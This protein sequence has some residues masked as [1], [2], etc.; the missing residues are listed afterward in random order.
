V[1]NSKKTILR[2]AI[3]LCVAGILL[4]ITFGA[5]FIVSNS[6]HVDVQYSVNLSHTVKDSVV[7]LNAAV[8]NN[9]NP[10]GNGYIVDFYYSVDG[11][12][13]WVHFDSRLTDVTGVV[14]TIYTATTNGGYD[15][16]AIASIP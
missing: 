15:F 4:T 7:T 1:K 12:A 10:V 3:L 16:R 8:S 13:N 2:V 11:G 9:G 14:Q 6:V 5:I